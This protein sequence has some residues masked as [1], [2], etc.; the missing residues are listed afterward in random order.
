MRRISLKE[1][2][3][4]ESL[5]IECRFSMRL[6]LLRY[7]S[8][9]SKLL[10]TLS[11][12]VGIV[13][14]SFCRK[15]NRR[16]PSSLFRSGTSFRRALTWL[17]SP[18]SASNALSTA[19]MSA[20]QTRTGTMRAELGVKTCVCLCS[21]EENNFYWEFLSCSIH[22]TGC[23]NCSRLT[24][25]HLDRCLNSCYTTYHRLHCGL[26][27][28]QRPPAAAGQERSS[29]LRHV[30]AS[31]R[32]AS[33]GSGSPKPEMDKNTGALCQEINSLA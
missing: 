1:R 6:M 7:R 8:R 17:Y 21:K 10:T 18:D 22:S 25:R 12:H 9:C 5:V 20:R 19:S 16:N 24:W 32:A 14:I 13:S 15:T 28:A 30:L 29:T 27:V 26:T 23:P 2:S 4:N 3:R 31:C 33:W 11:G